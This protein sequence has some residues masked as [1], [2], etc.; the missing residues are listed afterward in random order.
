M[1]FLQF[2]SNLLPSLTG[3]YPPDPYNVPGVSTGFLVR[4]PTTEK[5]AKTMAYPRLPANKLR[6]PAGLA[7]HEVLSLSLSLSRYS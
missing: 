6:S 7:I 5:K 4:Y 2:D 1:H 3:S